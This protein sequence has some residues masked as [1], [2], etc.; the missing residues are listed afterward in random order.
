MLAAGADPEALTDLIVSLI[1]PEGY[2]HLVE[3][4]GWSADAYREWVL[5]AFRAFIV[6]GA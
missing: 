6:P 2:N 1:A 4:S 3:T 5:Q